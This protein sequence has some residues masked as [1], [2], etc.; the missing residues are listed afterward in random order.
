MVVERARLMMMMM[1]MMMMQIIIIF[2]ED[3]NFT[4][5]DLQGV[6]SNNIAKNYFNIQ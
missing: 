2:I 5:S 3:A 4:I 1:M 6:H